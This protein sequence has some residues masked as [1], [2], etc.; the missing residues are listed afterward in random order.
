MSM[1][2]A[3]IVFLTG[4]A[5]AASAASLLVR[6]TTVMFGA[7]ESAATVTVTNS[8][9]TPMTA[10]L[11]LF[12]WDQQLNE[13]KLEPTGAVV[14]S[15]PML[16]I[17]PGKSQTIRLV[18]VQGTPATSQ[19]NYRLLVDEIPDRAAREAGTG[20]VVQLRYSVPVF[21]TA[22]AKP[23]A[24]ATVKASVDGNS[25][26]LDVAN[27]G[28]AHAQI[29]NVRVAF[30]DGSTSVIGA[31][32]VGYVLPDKQRQWKLNLPAGPAGGVKPTRVRTQI[33]GKDLL[34][35]L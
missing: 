34:V 8:G 15:P 26:V 29:S 18:R 31:G 20:V 5:S 27:R 21:V 6:P 22:K 33:N 28:N 16:E 11:R 19:E 7:G 3:M 4:G 25:L 13:D 30:A 1:R 17:P 10:Q 9:N 14:A 35:A 32:L 2:L 24:N 12:A 23:S